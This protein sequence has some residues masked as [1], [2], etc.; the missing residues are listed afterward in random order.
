VTWANLA[1][2]AIGCAVAVVGGLH[3]VPGLLALGSSIV[4]GVLGGSIPARAGAAADHRSE[5]PTSPAMA[6]RRRRR[7]VTPLGGPF[8]P[9]NTLRNRLPGGGQ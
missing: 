5:A 4:G 9:E 3:N 7:R 8:A 6:P 1:A 2:L